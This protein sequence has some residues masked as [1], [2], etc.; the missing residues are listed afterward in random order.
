MHAHACVCTWKYIWIWEHTD[1]PICVMVCMQTLVFMNVGV[2]LCACGSPQLP[3][4]HGFI[5]H[6]INV[7]HDLRRQ[8][9]LAPFTHAVTHTLVH[10]PTETQTVSEKPMW[11]AHNGKMKLKLHT[12]NYC[13][14]HDNTENPWW[15][16]D[17]YTGRQDTHFLW[18]LGLRWNYLLVCIYYWY[19]CVCVCTLC[20]THCLNPASAVAEEWSQF[21]CYKSCCSA[22]GHLAGCTSTHIESNVELLRAE[23]DLIVYYIY[24]YI[25]V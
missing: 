5:K 2:C 1:K 17:F 13:I 8:I 14:T 11:H 15:Q 23:I 10:A 4:G 18:Q 12:G 22:K 25:Y 9:K 16:A 3:F 6:F 24:I 21:R 20:V 7:K 19:Y